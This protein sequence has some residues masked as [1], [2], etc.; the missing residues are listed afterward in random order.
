MYKITHARKVMRKA[1]EKDEGFKMAYIAMCIYDNKKTKI[2]KEL[3]HEV[4]EDLLKVI[5]GK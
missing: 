5:F 3:C 4:A 2:S 1:F